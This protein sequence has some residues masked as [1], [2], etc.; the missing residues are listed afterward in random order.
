MFVALI[1][2]V[3]MLAGNVCAA[4][5]S[6]YVFGVKPGTMINS[7]HMGYKFGSLV[8]SIGLDVLWISGEYNS[9]DLYQD[10]TTKELTTI[11]MSG[12]ALLMLPHFGAKLYFGGNTD[13]RPYVY[14]NLFFSFSSVKFDMT[15]VYEE[16]DGGDYS[17]DEYEL[18]A[19]E[20][21]DLVKD[22][23]GFWGFTLAGGAEYFM[24]EH[25]SVGGEYG[26]RLLFDS[27]E[28]DTG[29]EESGVIEKME[30]DVSAS[31][32]STYTAVSLNYHF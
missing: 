32:K 21:V 25:F 2:L 27:V 12:R 9:T 15:R 7:A 20:A 29:S 4:E 5:D 30:N 1:L 28:Y 31:L 19:D 24:G 10:A 3:G 6:G 8:P 11:D 13:V 18:D 22:I 14:G 16:W 23:L 26:F 17:R